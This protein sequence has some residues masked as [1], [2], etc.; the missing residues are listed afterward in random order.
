MTID[1]DKM[2]GDCGACKSATT[3]AAQLNALKAYN[4]DKASKLERKEQELADANKKMEDLQKEL[5]TEKLKLQKLK[6]R[7][8][9]LV[10]KHKALAEDS[11]QLGDVAGK[12]TAEADKHEAQIKGL[13]EVETILSGK[14]IKDIGDTDAAL[15]V[16]NSNITKTKSS[17]N[18]TKLEGGLVEGKISQIEGTIAEEAKKIEQGCAAIKEN[19]SSV[20]W[21]QD[22]TDVCVKY[23]HIEDAHVVR[24]DYSS[25]VGNGTFYYKFQ[26]QNL[27][28]NPASWNS[29]SMGYVS[30]AKESKDFVAKVA[31][32]VLSREGE[33]PAVY[34]ARTSA[35]TVEN[36]VEQAILLD[37]DL[38]ASNSMVN[39]NCIEVFF[40]GDKSAVAVEVGFCDSTHITDMNGTIAY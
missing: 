26:G 30:L 19:K 20:I 27:Q 15:N 29:G 31:E 10:E 33:H 28:A 34:D 2:P 22:D 36:I 35:A 3:S 17:I 37:P 40:Q 38:S 13:L 16:T 23:K 12:L 14:F 4:K 8:G 6:T 21:R 25:S 24:V 1:V 5:Q 32:V 7:H 11:V 39:E 9:D 18:A